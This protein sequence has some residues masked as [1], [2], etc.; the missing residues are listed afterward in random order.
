MI[1][2]MIAYELGGY[3]GGTFPNPWDII[4]TI[5]YVVGY[6]NLSTF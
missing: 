2:E 6:G 1:A 3:D 4:V 5:V